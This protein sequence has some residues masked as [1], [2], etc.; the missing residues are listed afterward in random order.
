L[1]VVDRFESYSPPDPPSPSYLPEHAKKRSKA[2]AIG[3]TRG[4]MGEW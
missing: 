4:D 1:Q 2:A 3:V